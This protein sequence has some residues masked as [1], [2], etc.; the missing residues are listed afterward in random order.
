MSDG[1]RPEYDLVMPF[2][3]CASVGGP[4]DDASY[5]AGFA[6]GRLDAVLQIAG[7]L[8]MGSLTETVDAAS[9]QQADLLAMRRG[10]TATFTESELPEWIY[11]QFEPTTEGT[12]E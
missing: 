2:V 8:G 10:F 1:D 9:K 6:M 7:Q 12:P 5:V 11:A 4:H 3:T